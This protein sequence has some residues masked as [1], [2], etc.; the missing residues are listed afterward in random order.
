MKKENEQMI[1]DIL[2]EPRTFGHFNK[3]NV[4]KYINRMEPMSDHMRAYLIAYM[5]VES[6]DAL[7]ELDE[8]YYSQMTSAQRKAFE[9]E[10]FQ[11]MENNLN[12]FR[13]LA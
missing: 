6:E 5:T 12:H 7:K 11:C 8:S 9:N 4:M 13:Q 1:N 2:N 10:F 3:H